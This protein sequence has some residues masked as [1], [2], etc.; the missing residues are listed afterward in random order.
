MDLQVGVSIVVHRWLDMRRGE[1]LLLVT[2][3]GHEREAE[4]FERWAR[5]ADAA[6]STLILPRA[7]VQRGDVISAAQPLLERASAIIGATDAS[8][9]TSGA[10][11]SAVRRGARFLSLP[12]SC[13]DGGSLLEQ[14]FIGMDPGWAR[15]M[16]N[17]LLRTLN[18]ADAIRITTE[19]GTDL[20]FFK[21]GRKGGVYCGV[22]AHRGAIGS[23]SFEVYIPIEEHET[24]GRMILDGSLGY[25]G[26]VESPIEVTF[27]RGRLQTDRST[28]DGARLLSYIEHFGCEN[29]YQAAELG[30]GLNALS[31]CRGV[32]YIEDE[33][34]YQTFHIGLGR[35]LTLGGQ[36]DAAGHFDIVAH[37]PTLEADG[38]VLMRDGHLAI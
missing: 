16:G 3:E 21:R 23:A 9:L 13:R 10:V 5:S 17:R 18:R 37:C 26:L 24:E 31:R 33:S 4:A 28:P 8:F 27:S 12:L 35:N 14:E 11:R 1:L 6:L 7:Q 32:S 22:A 19:R 36:Q 25:L 34:A 20:R 29:L 38:V 30:I 15:H 2:D